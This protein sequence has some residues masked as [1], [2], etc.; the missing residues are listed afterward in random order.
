MNLKG[1]MEKL[2]VCKGGVV[3]I[4]STLVSLTILHHL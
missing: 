3:E 1:V 4:E 2:I